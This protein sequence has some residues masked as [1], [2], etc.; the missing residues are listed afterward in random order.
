MFG[1]GGKREILGVDIGS[2][3]VKLV[4]LQP[5]RSG[6]KLAA[7]GS[8][9]LPP[10]AVVDHTI[11][12]AGAVVEALKGLLTNQKIQAKHVATAVRGHA[13]IVR[14]I[15]L[16]QMEED[17]L[18]SSIQWEAEQYIPFDIAEVYL[19]YQLL[20]PVEGD[21]NQMEAVLVAAKRDFVDDY[22]SVFVETGLETA[23]VDVDCYALESAF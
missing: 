18:E 8:A 17:E 9:P 20:G 23:V 21:P 22:L 5:V 4:Q 15:Q 12:D 2:S 7:L 10:E 1:L 6:Y 14:K 19:D 13:V 3:S 16:P 11:M